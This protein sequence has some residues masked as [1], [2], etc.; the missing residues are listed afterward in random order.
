ME[1]IVSYLKKV[2]SGQTDIN[3][4]DKLD[5][6]QKGTSPKN[7]AMHGMFKGLI[8]MGQIPSRKE[9]M[10]VVNSYWPLYD[11]DGNGV[12]DREEARTLV[13]DIL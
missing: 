4:I 11:T 12:L 6:N 2:Q 13:G 7:F 8:S 9:A 5:C 1:E 10:R 3:F